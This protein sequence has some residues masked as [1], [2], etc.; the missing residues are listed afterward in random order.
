MPWQAMQ[1]PQLQPV[2]ASVWLFGERAL[3]GSDNGVD[4]CH[5]GRR[6]LKMHSDGGRGSG[7]VRHR[8]ISHRCAIVI[9]DSAVVCVRFVGRRALHSSH[10][11][12]HRPLHHVRN[13]SIARRQRCQVRRGVGRELCWDDRAC[14]Q[15][16]GSVLHGD[17]AVDHSRSHNDLGWVQPVDPVSR[18]QPHA[19]VHR[20]CVIHRGRDRCHHKVCPED[21]LLGEGGVVCLSE[22]CLF[23]V[24]GGEERSTSA[25][26]L[27][28]RVG[29]DVRD[30]GVALHH[31]QPHLRI[32]FCVKGPDALVT[33]PTMCPENWS[34]SGELE[35]A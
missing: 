5:G 29:E 27:E 22:A 18:R 17:S 32:P 7:V 24:H 35:P 15:I 10:D 26:S 25:V 20:R 28:C 1:S 16:N 9:V 6:P 8:A 31:A 3:G 2:R 14:T 30:E 4:G 33:E 34:P 11:P 19:L 12:H 23:P 13:R 21:V